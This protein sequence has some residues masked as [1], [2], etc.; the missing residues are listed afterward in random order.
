M[1]G[2]GLPDVLGLSCMAPESIPADMGPP[3]RGLGLVLRG[4]AVDAIQVVYRVGLFTVV[5]GLMA[6]GGFV[7]VLRGWLDDRIVDWSDVVESLGGVPLVG[8]RDRDAGDLGLRLRR[9]D[10]PDLHALMIQVARKLGVRPP[11][12]VRLAYVPC[13]G[14]IDRRESHLLLVGMPLLQVLTIAELRAVLA[15]E[16]AHLARGDAARSARSARFLDALERGLERPGSWGP[17][18]AWAALVRWPTAALVAPIARGQEARADHL[19]AQVAGGPT[20]A[21]SL[22]KVAMIQPLFQEVLDFYDVDRQEANLYAF[23]RDFWGRLPEPLRT[24]LRH[25]LLTRPDTVDDSTHPPLLDRIRRTQ[26]VADRPSAE[27][28]LLI[29]N[30]DRTLASILLGDPEAVEQELHDRLF[31]AEAVD[32]SVF[33]RSGS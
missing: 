10:A 30:P 9:S 15:H 4:L 19:A 3:A 7:V 6:V 18:R 28:E 12:E 29:P 21:A 23:F 27:F 20:A 14:V 13:C 24:T 8:R 16:L 33:H 11:S 25:R 2:N 22:V 1:S 32:R 26:Q 17:L 31:R 5:T